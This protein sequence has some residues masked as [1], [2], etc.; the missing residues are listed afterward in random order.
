MTLTFGVS[1]A[2][3][4]SGS[5]AAPSNG[6]QARTT[7]YGAAAMRVQQEGHHMHGNEVSW[8]P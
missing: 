3:E 7:G 8:S 5:D 2:D 1:G 6:K 4:D